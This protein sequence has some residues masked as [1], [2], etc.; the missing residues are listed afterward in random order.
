MWIP[1]SVDADVPYSK[2]YTYKMCANIL[3]R[4][5]LICNTVSVLHCLGKTRTKKACL[6][7]FSTDAKI[8]IRSCWNKCKGVELTDMELNMELTMNKFIVK[9]YVYVCVL[10]CSCKCP[11]SP[12]RVLDCLELELQGCCKPPDV[13]GRNLAQEQYLHLTADERFWNVSP[14]GFDI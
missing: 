4:S 14:R 6:Y 8:L 2:W 11:W 3:S 5:L 13:G 9:S 1:K 12:E 7:V 10:T